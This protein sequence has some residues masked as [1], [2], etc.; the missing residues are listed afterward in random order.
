MPTYIIL[1]YKSI[2]V[3][4]FYN[5]LCH[6]NLYGSELVLFFTLSFGV[7]FMVGCHRHIFSFENINYVCDLRHSKSMETPKISL[8][9]PSLVR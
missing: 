9:Q 6:C 5:L 3:T 7:T 4:K 1:P 2:V 8:F